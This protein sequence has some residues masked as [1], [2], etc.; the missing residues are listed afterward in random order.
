MVNTIRH[1]AYMM[2]EVGLGFALRAID[3]IYTFSFRPLLLLL[4]AGSCCCGSLDNDC[5]R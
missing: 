5:F 1:I 4:L 2:A 3:I